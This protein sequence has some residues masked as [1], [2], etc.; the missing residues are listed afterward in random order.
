MNWKKINIPI[1]PQI[2]EQIASLLFNWGASGLE[3]QND[4]F[5]VYFP[6]SV[7]SADKWDA[8]RGLLKSLVTDSDKID[9]SVETIPDQNWNE[10]WKENFKP[11]RVSERIIIYP[12]WET[13]QPRKEELAIMISPKMAFGTGHHETTRMVLLLM[14]KYFKAGMR[15]LDAGTGSGILA[16][17]AAKM[18]AS[19]MVAFDNDPVAMANCRENFE[20][21]Q[22][23]TPTQLFTGTLD[24]IH[25]QQFHMIT[26]NIERNVLMEMAHDLHRLVVPGGIAILSGLLDRDAAT[27]AALYKDRGWNLIEERQDKEWMALVLRY[28]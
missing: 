12:E 15:F 21:N 8:L 14:E 18:G 19:E 22:I 1:Q 26:A 7:W 2:L 28:E 4:S 3:E 13:Y 9:I 27:V 23:D 5:S 6:Q 17:L 20:L 16:L 10:S 11:L 25:G 24:Y